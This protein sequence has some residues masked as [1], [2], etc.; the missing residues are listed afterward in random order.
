MLLEL[1]NKE[2]KKNH[3]SLG[4][5]MKGEGWH[6]APSEYVWNHSTCQ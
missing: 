6:F 4:E 5:L 1:Y 2:L 3:L